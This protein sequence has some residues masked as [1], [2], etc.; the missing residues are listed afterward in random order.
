MTNSFTTGNYYFG[1]YM[2]TGNAGTY[3]MYC[4][5]A[6]GG[7]VGDMSSAT[8]TSAKLNPGLGYVTINATTMPTAVAVNTLVGT[9]TTNAEPWLLLTGVALDTGA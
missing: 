7:F 8:T 2:S 3:T 4:Q 1:I 6:T 9:G 5:N